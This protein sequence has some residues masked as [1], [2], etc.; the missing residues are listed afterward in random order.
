MAMDPGI[1]S[2]LLSLNTQ[3]NILMRERERINSLF[4]DTLATG[5][6]TLWSL[7]TTVNHTSVKNDIADNMA[8][9]NTVLT[10]AI[11]SIRDYPS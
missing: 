11:Q 5:G 1:S 4:D 7:L 10:A 2:F 9:A 8:A 3:I 6:V